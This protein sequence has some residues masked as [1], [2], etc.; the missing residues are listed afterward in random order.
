[1]PLC[2]FAC[3]AVSIVEE[4]SNQFLLSKGDSS[5]NSCIQVEERA[6]FINDIS[7]FLACKCLK[8]LRNDLIRLL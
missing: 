4:L 5:N 7:R 8:Y 6:V 1:M 2:L 3:C